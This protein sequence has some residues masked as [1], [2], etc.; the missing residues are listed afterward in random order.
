M[1]KQ[2]YIWLMDGLKQRGSEGELWYLV[3]LDLITHSNSA[4]QNI[5]KTVLLISYDIPFLNSVVNLYIIL[6]KEN[7]QDM[8]GTTMN[9]R[10]FM[11]KTKRNLKLHM[12]GNR[13][14]SQELKILLQELKPILRLLT[15]QDQDKS[16]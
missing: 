3:D 4:H 12:K 9:S 5:I 1:N 14:K 2:L 6:K 7:S 15:W 13:R 11:L 16:N 10:E 8:S